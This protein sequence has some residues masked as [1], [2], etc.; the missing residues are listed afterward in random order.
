LVRK[1]LVNLAAPLGNAVRLLVL[2]LPGLLGVALVA[3][4]A[5]LW[6]PPAGFVAAGLLLL[7]DRAWEQMRA[8][9]RAK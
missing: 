8:D 4:G 1:A 7:V 6:W 5:W 3:Y 9:R 2:A